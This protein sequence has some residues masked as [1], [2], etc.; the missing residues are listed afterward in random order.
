MFN[1]PAIFTHPKGIFELKLGHHPQASATAKLTLLP[2]AGLHRARSQALCLSHGRAGPGTPSLAGTVSSASEGS[3]KPETSCQGRKRTQPVL[4]GAR[5]SSKM[6]KEGCPVMGGRVPVSG[7]APVQP[8]SDGRHSPGCRTES[9]D[10]SPRRKAVA[11]RRGRLVHRPG[12]QA[13]RQPEACTG[14]FVQP[15][16]GKAPGPSPTGSKAA[17]LSCAAPPATCHPATCL[18]SPPSD[19]L[20]GPFSETINLGSLRPTEGVGK[21]GGRN[22]GGV[23]HHPAPLQTRPRDARLST[24]HPQTIQEGLTQ[25]RGHGY[26]S[27]NPSCSVP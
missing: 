1:T 20:A 12:R 2:Q 5:I 16:P 26:H 7:P 10:A 13:G 11:S 21:A 25:A 22:T 18:H 14:R 23:A 15:P 24:P 27:S 4:F 3:H 6:R 17:V 9:R 8:Q 19:A